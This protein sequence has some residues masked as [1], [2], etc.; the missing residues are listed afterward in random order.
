MGGDAL[1]QARDWREVQLVQLAHDRYFHPDV[2]G[3]TKLEQL[4]HYAFH[5]AKFPA[6]LTQASDALV[7]PE[8]VAD[9]VL[10][11][12]KLQTVTGLSLP[13]EPVDRSDDTLPNWVTGIQ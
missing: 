5:A 8:R 13:P 11:G 1:R 2:L 4:R 9:M 10:F 6:F 7:P 12:I 3:L